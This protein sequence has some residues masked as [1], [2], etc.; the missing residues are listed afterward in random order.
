MAYKDPRELSKELIKN[1][2]VFDYPDS[3]DQINDI[4]NDGYLDEVD[5]GDGYK[6][7]PN[8]RKVYG[9][10]LDYNVEFDITNGDDIIDTLGVYGRNF[11]ED[12]QSQLQ[13]IIR[14]HKNNLGGN[15]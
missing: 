10:G 2:F 6:L 1:K 15:K 12:Y 4:L 14:K 7:F 11:D 3:L 9:R 8:K 5:L 13:D